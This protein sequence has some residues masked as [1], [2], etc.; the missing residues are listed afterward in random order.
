LYLPVGQ[1]ID[2]GFTSTMTLVSRSR[3]STSLQ[4]QVDRAMREIDPDFVAVRSETLSDAIAL[5]LGPQRLL[6]GVA[7][8]LGL[9]GLVLAAIGIHGM[10]AYAVAQR[11]R[12]FGI[13]I[14]LGAPRAGIVWM[15]L[16]QGLWIVTA[17]SAFG[18]SVAAGIGRMLS[19]VFYGL[20]AFHVPTFVGILSLVA[21]A[22]AV[23]CYLPARKAVS[24]DPLRALRSE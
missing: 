15:V 24:R 23:A 7:G 20:P 12:E 16:R 8:G 9:I 22:S 3:N 2:P 5:G 21:V 13:R 18:L 14:A 4:L 17:G 11:R 6:A 1:T 10:M 19:A